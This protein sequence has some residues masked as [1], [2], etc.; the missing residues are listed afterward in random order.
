MK[1]SGGESEEGGEKERPSNRGAIA[2]Y[3]F[4]EGDYKVM[5]GNG[6][7]FCTHQADWFK[8]TVNTCLSISFLYWRLALL[9]FGREKSHGFG[10]TTP[11]L[12]VK[13]IIE[14]LVIQL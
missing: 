4:Y 14:C 10:L 3:I 9:E 5:A 8:R 1:P 7:N 12:D 2:G 6:Y 11:S 13:I